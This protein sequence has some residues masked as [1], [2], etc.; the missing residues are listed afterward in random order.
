MTREEF[1]KIVDEIAGEEY[2]HSMPYK[3]GVKGHY[4]P[5]TTL[6]IEWSTGGYEG[7]NCWDD[8]EP[9]YYSN[10]DCEPEFSD[11]DNI[12]GKVCP[13][14]GFLQY[15]ALCKEVITYNTRSESEYYGNSTDYSSKSISVNAL[16]NTLVSKGL[17]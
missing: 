12:L 14:I 13:Q 2:V 17:V 1:Q 9:R 6:K 15:K 10:G 5:R 4:I 3:F 7:G 11:L 8:T 16:Y